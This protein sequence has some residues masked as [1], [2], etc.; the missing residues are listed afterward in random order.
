MISLFIEL[1]VLT[2][3]YSQRQIYNSFFFCLDHVLLLLLL[4]VVAVLSQK[5]AKH[6]QGAS[7]YGAGNSVGQ[8]MRARLVYSEEVC[9][10]DSKHPS[11]KGIF[12]VLLES[13]APSEYVTYEF[14]CL[15]SR[16]LSKTSVLYECDVRLEVPI[17][18]N[19]C[20]TAVHLAVLV[21]P[22]EPHVVVSIVLIHH[23][24][25]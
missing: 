22:R 17:V 1:I 15:Y 23:H 8:R 13:E 19:S 21:H 7:A 16:S 10:W 12:G 25:H 14:G 11:G 9:M 3:C 2:A 6:R 4:L 18:R 20:G 5:N 24:H